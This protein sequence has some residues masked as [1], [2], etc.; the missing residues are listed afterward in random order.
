MDA[1]ARSYSRHLGT[2]TNAQFQ[3][4]LDRFGLGHFLRAEPIP[5]GNFGQNVFLTSTTGEYVLRGR[6]HYPWQFPKERFFTQQLH[7]HTCAPVPWP[8]LL[9]PADDIFGWSY[10][11]MP[12]M[13]GL[14]L[15][16]PEVRSRLTKDDKL[17]IAR[18]MGEMLA[19]LQELRGPFAGEYD[20]ATG[21][22]RPLDAAYGDWVTARI[23]YNLQVALPLS[24]RTTAADVEWVEALIAQNRAA[25]DVELEPCFAMQDF[26]EGNA[27]VERADG[28]W[29]VSGVFDYMSAY[30]GD[31]EQD[32]PRLAGDYADEDPALA[33]EFVRA[34]LT[35]RPP[36]PGFAERYRL[37]MLDDRL[38]LWQFGQRH[39]VWWEPKL[40]LRE[41]AGPYVG[42]R[43]LDG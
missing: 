11:I 37:Y 14:Q 15:S 43:V 19:T 17:G 10:V 1:T 31:G 13:P 39:G 26:K 30:M 42:M 25:L 24:D 32:L 16:N 3:A 9:D 38:V 20:L 40:T 36:R 23:R 12:R 21:G 2:L 33:H 41:W 27:V 28:A 7:E 5:F 22:L 34:Y 6:P 18:A 8:Y 4:A 29:R 35:R